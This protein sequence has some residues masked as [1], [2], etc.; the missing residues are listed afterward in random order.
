VAAKRYGH[1]PAGSVL[2]VEKVTP[3]SKLV[4]PPVIAYR[5]SP[6]MTTSTDDGAQPS[7][8]LYRTEKEMVVEGEPEPG[9]A[10]PAVST[11]A[12]CLALLQLAATAR[13]AVA[14]RSTT[15]M[16]L[17]RASA[18]APARSRGG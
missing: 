4:P 11:G 13:P 1:E 12:S 5:P 10:A 14:G 18:V 3:V 16:A 7:L 2:D 9:E 17:T 8:S 15:S 6:T